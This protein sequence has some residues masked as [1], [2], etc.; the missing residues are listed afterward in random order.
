[1]S[2]HGAIAGLLL[3]GGASSRMGVDKARLRRGGRSLAE[4]AAG[5]LG[6][7]CDLLLE[8]GPGVGGLEAVREPEPGAGPL[9]AFAAGAAALH[10]RGHEGAVL[11]LAVDLP[12]VEASLLRLLAGH[13][14]GGT[15][16]VPVADGVPQPLCGRYQPDAGREA[17]R[18]VARGSRSMR[19]LLDEVAWQALP[20][21]VWR[22]VAS[23]HALDDVDTPADVERFRLEWPG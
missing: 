12:F 2:G 6:E 16:L 10:E 23:P 15:T 11:L 14:P 13:E 7:V 19:A 21:D 5:A 20:E 18:L 17:A 8:V 4:R 1:M 22:A 9:A 3:T